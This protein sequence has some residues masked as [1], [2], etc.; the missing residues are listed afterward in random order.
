MAALLCRIGRARLT[1]GAG[2]VMATMTAVAA[3]HE[4]VHQ[5]ASQQEKKRK[6]SER[7]DTVLGGQQVSGDRQE[8]DRDQAG[9]RS[10]KAWPGPSGRPG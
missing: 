1:A 9:S 3:M 10:P 4:E 7:V 6:I 8:A 2:A 5:R